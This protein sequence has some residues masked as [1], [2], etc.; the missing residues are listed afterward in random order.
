MD[1]RNQN[2]NLAIMY[3]FRSTLHNKIQTVW[4]RA[5]IQKAKML[6]LFNINQYFTHNLGILLS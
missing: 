5:E 4:T 2:N 3:T 1:I 6:H